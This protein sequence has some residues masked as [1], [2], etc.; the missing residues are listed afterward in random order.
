MKIHTMIILLIPQHYNIR[1]KK[2]TQLTDIKSLCLFLSLVLYE[3]MHM[4]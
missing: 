1:I 4:L 2:H 3:M